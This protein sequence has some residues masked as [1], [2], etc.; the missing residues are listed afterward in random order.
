MPSE[1]LDSWKKQ[2]GL[3]LEA[4]QDTQRRYFAPFTVQIP[5]ELHQRVNSLDHAL[6]APIAGE[7]RRHFRS[8]RRISLS[9]LRSWLS[10]RNT[11][12]HK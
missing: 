2:F 3:T 10:T 6:Q 4:R 5:K 12:D 9:G 7:T 8:R 1:E 11:V